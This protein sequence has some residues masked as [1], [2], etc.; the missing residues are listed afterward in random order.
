MSTKKAAS[1]QTVAA[2]AVGSV[3]ALGLAYWSISSALSPGRP[4]G[5]P[6]APVTANPPPGPTLSDPS[7]ATAQRALRTASTGAESTLSPESNPFAPISRPAAITAQRSAAAAG[8]PP[9]AAGQGPT[10]PTISPTPAGLSAV[11]NLQA[12]PMGSPGTAPSSRPAFTPPSMAQAPAVVKQPEL[13]GTLLGDQPSGVFQADKQLVIVPV[14]G[15]IDGWRVVAVDQGEA[16]V[17]MGKHSLRVLVGGSSSSRIVNHSDAASPSQRIAAASPDGVSLTHTSPA[18]TLPPF[19]VA[20]AP[21]SP[22]DRALQPG[23]SPRIP[24]EAAQT[25]E[26]EKPAARTSAPMSVLARNEQSAPQIPASSSGSVAGVPAA[27]AT[28]YPA[29]VS[30][31]EQNPFARHIAYHVTQHTGGTA[32]SGGSRTSTP[33]PAASHTTARRHRRHRHH[34]HLMHRRHRRHLHRRL[35][36]RR[37]HHPRYHLRFGH[38]RHI[39]IWRRPT[40]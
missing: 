21:P 33:Q 35:N 37:H 15:V 36:L 25:S 2:L 16:T 11:P 39:H 4:G 6:A 14:G 30:D 24:A 28:S 17:R 9:P 18:D 13:V 40:P 8:T 31:E 5:S 22:L 26:T 3:G 7:T 34:R 1:P 32:P 29:T 20:T 23:P 19:R 10:L 12:M 38:H 27:S